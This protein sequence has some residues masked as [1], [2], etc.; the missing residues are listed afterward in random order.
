MDWYVYKVD[1]MSVAEWR[2]YTVRQEPVSDRRDIHILARALVILDRAF[3]D[4]GWLNDR[5]EYWI[6]P[7]PLLPDLVCVRPHANPYAVG[8]VVSPMLLPQMNQY[9]MEQV[10]L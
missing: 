10:T 1:N 4:V 2:G 9:H 5:H 3:G 6:T 7:C 8:Y